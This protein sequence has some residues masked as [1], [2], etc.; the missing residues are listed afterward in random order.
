M[1]TKT[2]TALPDLDQ[3]RHGLDTAKTTLAEL[4]D[5]LVAGDRTVNPADIA[6]ARAA[7]DFAAL[8]LELAE[9][10]DARQT[11]DARQDHAAQLAARLTDGDTLTSPNTAVIDATTAV[12][13]A[14]SRLAAAT[15]H[16]DQV[17]QRAITALAAAGP[18]PDGL[19]VRHDRV[20]TSTITRAGHEIAHLPAA[21]TTTDTVLAAIG[22]GLRD[23]FPKPT[24]RLREVHATLRQSGPTPTDRLA[25]H[26][27][28][29]TQQQDPA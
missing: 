4:R 19:Q 25:G 14:I 24:G 28:A 12:V 29:L 1:A 26:N 5:K 13:D 3:A 6:A 17:V 15:R 20:M 2:R 11:A 22:H 23:A 27:A 18:L 7:V 9:A 8:Q 16:R 10:A 21:G